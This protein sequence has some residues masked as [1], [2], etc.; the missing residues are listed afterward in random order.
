MIRREKGKGAW[1]NRWT[2]QVI[3]LLTFLGAYEYRYY[4]ETEYIP[5][6]ATQAYDNKA[7]TEVVK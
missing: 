7:Y 6:N 2:E 4:K 1:R 3:K 5:S